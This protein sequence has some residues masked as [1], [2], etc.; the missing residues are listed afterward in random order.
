MPVEMSS[1]AMPLLSIVIPTYNAAMTVRSC[2][3]SIARQT[4]LEGVEVLVQDGNSTDST[5]EIVQEYA[6]LPIK[7]EQV[8]DRGVYDAMNLAVGRSAGRWLYFLGADDELHDQAV[9]GELLP[10]LADTNAHLLQ[11][12]AWLKNA[13][14]LHGAPTS[15]DALLH[16][17]NMCHQ[18]V[19]YR[20][21]L[22][23][24][25]GGYQLRYPIWADWEFNIR[26]FR[27]PDLLVEFWPRPLSVY[28]DQAGLSRNEDP[29][30]RKELPVCTRADAAKELDSL[31]FSRSYR[32]GR[33]LF[34]WLDRA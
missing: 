5:R 21:D 33:R 25:L 34:G 3:E 24:R 20:R 13:G 10:R 17:R 6:G 8:A 19:C 30:F 28:N 7:F 9:L 26:C 15:L 4:T 27:W 29:V 14:A 31:R 11:A 1:S 23:E 2:L 16:S 18:S 22:F 32:L 12:Q